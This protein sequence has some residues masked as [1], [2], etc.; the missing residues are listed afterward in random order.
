MM[1]RI[2]GIARGIERMILYSD[3][4]T[5]FVIIFA[6]VILGAFFMKGFGLKKGY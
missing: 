1:N 2:G 6:L 5:W 4:K 3:M